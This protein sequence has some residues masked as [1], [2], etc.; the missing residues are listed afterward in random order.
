MTRRLSV[1]AL[2]APILVLALLQLAAFWPGIMVW[3][4]IRQYGQA[5]SGRYDDWHPPV[6]NWLWRQFGAFGAG[7][8]PML[9]LQ[10]MLYWLG[11]GLLAVAMARTRGMKAG[12]AILACA[13]LPIP[14]WLVGTIL[15]DSLMEGALL[16]AA[17]LLAA[18]PAQD[19]WRG[20]LAAALL[21][22]A[23]TLRFN[24]AAA[25]L[26]L[27]VAALPLRWT[28]T[29]PRLAITAAIA[30]IPLLAAMP[31]ANRLLHAQKSGVE[32]SLVIYDLGGIA[33]FSGA[34]VMPPVAVAHSAAIVS[35]CWSPVSWD[36]Y[37]WWTAAPCPIGFTLLR[38]AFAASGQSPYRWWAQAIVAHPLAYAAHRL[39]HADRN[40]R[41]WV[42][43]ADLPGL[44]LASDPNPWG[45]QVPPSRL[46]DRMAAIATASTATPLGWP[47]CWLALGIGLLIAAPRREAGD[48]ALP[49]LWSAVLYALSY[50]PLSV[51]SEVRYHVWTMSAVALG[52][53][54]LSTRPRPFAGVAR[55]RIALA[56]AVP[57]LATA[58]AVVARL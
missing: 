49:L 53:V 24:A 10:V 6:M 13:L 47:A 22:A 37:A 7:P 30:L 1:P 18:R 58:V 39:A 26:P 20:A 52:G 57:L 8:G 41:L 33:H 28:R 54:M 44:S 32:L 50:V 15:K 5:L 19:R 31:I 29:P 14:F 40:L 17:G 38:P 11:F 34:Q 4:A 42:H 16:L 36:S 25:C 2:L 27:L 21:V 9:A 56:V 35:T 51:A 46:R 12:L 3:D 45:Y 23:A 55:L 43:D 48:I